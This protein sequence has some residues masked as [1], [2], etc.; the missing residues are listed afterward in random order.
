[1]KVGP[2]AI[3]RLARLTY[4]PG[5][6]R[7]ARLTP[8]RFVVMALFLPLLFSLVL[9]HWVCLLLDDLFF[10]AYRRRKIIAPLF[11]TGVPRSGTT[12]LQQLITKDSEQ[13]TTFPLWEIVF[14][15]AICQKMALLSLGHLDR[16]FGGP[17]KALLDVAEQGVFGPFSDIHR[18]SL[19]EPDED[20][21]TL[22]PMFAALLL[23]VPFPFRD[24]TGYLGH[25]DEETPDADRRALMRYYQGI[26]RRH[27]YVRGSDKRFLSKNPMLSPMVGTLI[28]AFP[29]CQIISTVR[30]PFNTV[31][32]FMNLMAET[33]ALFDTGRGDEEFRDAWLAVIKFMYRNLSECL[34]KLPMDQYVFVDYRDLTSNPRQVM[35][36]LYKR[37]E[38]K[39]SSTYSTRLQ[40]EHNQSRHFKSKHQYTL[41][42]FFLTPEQVLSEMQF[43]FDEFGFDERCPDWLLGQANRPPAESPERDQLTQPA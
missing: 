29:D 38:L 41:D 14:A 5:N 2:F 12:F 40:A 30:S 20:Y 42:Q 35:E 27:L 39:I 18:L 11:I 37:L 21:I 3:F 10:P 16:F 43:V 4:F 26:I 6:E 7:L 34:P 9:F 24:A 32:S 23:F 25:F 33:A 8:K 31:P 17:G 1:M 22:L 28:E 15:P 13:F 19:F 36:G